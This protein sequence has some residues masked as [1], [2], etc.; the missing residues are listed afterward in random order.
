MKNKMIIT[1]ILI[2]I[3]VSLLFVF[4]LNNSKNVSNANLDDIIQEKIGVID[5]SYRN[6]T[7]IDLNETTASIQ[8]KKVSEYDYTWHVD[9]SV[10]HN[11]VK[12]AP[13]EYYTG[14]LPD[15]LEDIYIDHELY[16]Y[17]SL[18][19]SKF[20]LVNYDG[21]RE[22]AYYYNDGENDEY[23]FST[24]PN[25]GGE[26]PESMMHTE[27]EAM[28]NKVLHITKEGTYILTGS[29]KGQ[30]KVDLGDEENFTDE[31]KKVTLILNGVNINCTV[32]PGLIFENLYECDNQWENKDFQTYTTDLTNAGVNLVIAD[33][34]ENIISGNNIFRMLKT[35][36]KDSSQSQSVSEQ[37]VS[38][39]KK[40][41]KLDGALYSYVSI[42]VNGGTVGNGK[43]QIN[44]N[45][46]GFNSELHIAVNSGN[47]IIHSKDDGI[48]VNED[49]VSTFIING[50]AL[51]INASEGAEGDGIDSNGYAVI[52]DGILQ[53]NNVTALDNAIDTN[54]GI[55]YKGGTIYIDGE[56]MT[57]TSGEKY[58]EISS[59]NQGFNRFDKGNFDKDNPESNRPPKFDVENMPFPDEKWFSGDRAN[60]G[61]KIL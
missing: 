61:N 7:I 40:M 55:Y 59:K 58:K 42:N 50:G 22:W 28:Q 37:D 26:L 32:A 10:N 18:D 1:L 23:I 29:W 3:V 39:Q 49:H 46:E 9:P 33:E 60:R 34:S 25:L 35:K 38:T 41:R 19:S 13:A 52:N 56:K 11:D 31:S 27:E 48:N 47:V 51:K 53:I 21:E 20:K 30:I 36:F 5:E 14:T 43:L 54:D 44:S 57:Y 6:A 2:I 8:G 4:I 15:N 16:Y 12:D 24:L 17:P 45:F